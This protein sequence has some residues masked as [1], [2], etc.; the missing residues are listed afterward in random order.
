MDWLTDKNE[1]DELVQELMIYFYA[2]ESR[3]A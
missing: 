3:N 1:V 2:N